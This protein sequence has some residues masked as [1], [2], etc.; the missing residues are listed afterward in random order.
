MLHRISSHSPRAGFSLFEALIVMVIL[1]LLAGIAI[2]RVSAYQARARDTRRIQDLGNL[3]EAIESFRLEK[4]RYPASESEVAGWDSSS[5]GDLAPELITEGFWRSPPR[6]P[7]EDAEH[8]VRYRVYPRGSHGCF[9]PASYYVLGVQNL[10]TDWARQRF[11]STFV[12]PSHSWE[13]ELAYS[14]GGGA[15]FSAPRPPSG[16]GL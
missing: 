6:D 12:C 16:P 8:S 10:E 2:P 4:G 14:T 13:D 5:D 9:G 3:Q 15:S 1:S 7:L 11:Q